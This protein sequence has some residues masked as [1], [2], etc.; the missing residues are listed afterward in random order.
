MNLTTSDL[1][2][3]ALERGVARVRCFEDLLQLFQG[4]S[5]GLNE[6][7]VDEGNLD[8]DPGNVDQVQLPS[9]LL[10]TNRDT[11]CVDDHGN[12]EEE[13]VGPR[14]LGSSPVLQTLYSVQGLKRCPTPSEDDAEAIDRDDSTVGKIV[15]RLRSS[16]KG[17]QENV[18][19]QAACKTAK[20]H[21]AATELVEKGSSVDSTNHTEDWVNGINEQLLVRIIDS[22]VLDHRRHEVGDDVV[23]TP[24]P[25]KCHSD[26]HHHP[27][28][29][30]LGVVELAEVPPRVV[31]ACG[32]KVLGDFTQLKLDKGV[33]LV[34]I[35]VVFGHDCDSLLASVL[36][37]EPTGRF[38]EPHDAQHDKS[39]DQALYDCW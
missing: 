21:L 22:S 29:G 15:C 18:E 17:S 7:E 5:S 38:R 14:T 34:A 9:D 16:G 1:N 32:C 13:E 28:T 37:Q 36:C 39:W 30:S 23:S 3:S 26:N 35:T 8:T 11:V 25:K 31:V 10:H 33:V 19:E 2:L 24:L 12:V 6:E 20:Q 27:V 4:F